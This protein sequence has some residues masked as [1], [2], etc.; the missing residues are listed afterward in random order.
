[1]LM[2]LTH[3]QRELKKSIALLNDDYRFRKLYRSI[4]NNFQIAIM[5]L[6]SCAMPEE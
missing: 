2:V 4:M 3:H 5:Q 1:V 6:L